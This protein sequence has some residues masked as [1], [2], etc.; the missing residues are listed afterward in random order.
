M[1]LDIL[2]N[3][4]MQ[5]NISSIYWNVLLYIISDIIHNILYI[6]VTHINTINHFVLYVFI[7]FTYEIFKYIL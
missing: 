6:Y 4:N 5:Y 7:Y 1:G 2:L 3:F